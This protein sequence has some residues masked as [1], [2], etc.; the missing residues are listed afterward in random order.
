MAPER[1]VH[2]SSSYIGDWYTAKCVC[3]KEKYLSEH[4]S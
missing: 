2:D 1:G 4:L 3:G